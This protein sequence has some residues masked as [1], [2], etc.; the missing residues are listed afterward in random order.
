MYT[1][2]AKAQKVSALSLDMCGAFPHADRNRLIEILVE[3]GIPGYIVRIIRSWLCDRQT[4]LEMPG[5]DGQLFFENGGLPQG[6]CLS[7]FLFLIF[8]APL[9]DINS[10]M[11]REFFQVFAFVDDTYITVR[12]HT[13]EQNCKVL[14]WVHAQLFQWSNESGITF[15][16]AKYGLI[17]F[18]G[19]ADGKSEVRIRPRIDNLPPDEVLFDKPYLVILGV[20]VDNRLSWKYHVE[21][22]IA[23]VSKST[24]CLKEISGANWGPELPEMRMLYTSQIQPIFSYASPAWFITGLRK[25]RHGTI[26]CELVKQLDALQSQCLIELSGVMKTTSADVLRKELC[27]PKM[28][29][30]LRMKTVAYF[31]KHFESPNYEAFR[32]E[33]GAALRDWQLRDHPIQQLEAQ[34]EE[35]R[36]SAKARLEH[37]HGP[38]VAGERWSTHHQRVTAIDKMAMQ[39]VKAQC[40]SD[41]QEFKDG[42]SQNHFSPRPLALAEPWGPQSLRYH[43]FLTREESTM[44]LHCRTGHIGLAAHLHRFG[45]YPTDLCPF[46]NAGPHTVEHLFIHCTGSDCTG[47]SMGPEAGRN[48][49]R[50]SRGHNQPAHHLYRVP[51]GGRQLCH[52]GLWHRPVHQVQLAGQGRAEARLPGRHR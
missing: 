6:S 48:P 4:V 29:V 10:L 7:P 14:E 13:F 33:R 17:H 27:I 37:I 12:S 41:W 25:K 22:I 3:K 9:F 24:R 16:P 51:R 21:H 40:S 49:L 39:A 18:L 31:A 44:L 50:I 32:S 43:D 20:R 38:D 34:A 15:E 45:L 8:A 26:S 5:H 19:P 11:I 42:W 35:L 46:C 28:S 47:R 36:K 2:W 30:Y 1:G 52:Q 23:Q